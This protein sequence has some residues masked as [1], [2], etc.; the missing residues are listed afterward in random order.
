MT[1]ICILHCSLAMNGRFSPFASAS[2]LTAGL[3]LS[4]SAKRKK[5]SA[6]KESPSA[7]PNL[8]KFY[9][10]DV[11]GPPVVIVLCL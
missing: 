4:F 8:R 9:P 7:G 6:K 1:G 2:S 3:L 5:D 10:A 11:D